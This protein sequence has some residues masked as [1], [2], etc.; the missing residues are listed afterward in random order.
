M[1]LQKNSRS[2]NLLLL[3]LLALACPSIELKAD[4]EPMQLEATEQEVIQNDQNINEEFFDEELKGWRKGLHWFLA[5]GD[6]VTVGALKALSY[7]KTEDWFKGIPEKPLSPEA[8]AQI[9]EII[10]SNNINPDTIILKGTQ[11]PT[12]AIAAALGK[13]GMLVDPDQVRDFTK[14]EIEFVVA[15][16]LGHLKHKD[17]IKGAALLL[18]L[19]FI[20]HFGLKAWD[21]A[22]HKILSELKHSLGVEKDSR[23]AQIIAKIDYINHWL[24]TFCLTKCV[25]AWQLYFA[26]TRYCE[27][28]ADFAA[29]SHLKT[30]E[31][32]EAV[33]KKVQ[34]E[35][36]LKRKNEVLGTWSYT[37]QGDTIPP[38]SHPRSS[39]RIA[40][41][42]EWAQAYPKA[43][44]VIIEVPTIV[45]VEVSP[46]SPVLVSAN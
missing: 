14:A 17:N 38:L 24:S 18:A 27:R 16:E 22:I 25:V 28:Q 15:H 34:E 20:S 37:E 7:Y 29:I 21:A 44:P 10:Q 43:E 9:K 11:L 36:K 2:Q 3:A 46:L 1:I 31:G 32:A 45:P 42:R 23:T 5:A 26:Y 19:P 8:Y 40:Y 30:S 12:P 4:Q 33:F 6:L 39:E 41:T 35:C 13:N